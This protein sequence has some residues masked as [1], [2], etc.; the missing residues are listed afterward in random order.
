MDER[1]FLDHL[2]EGSGTDRDA[3]RV[4]DSGPRSI[5]VYFTGKSGP[6]SREFTVEP[7]GDTK[8]KLG[9]LFPE[10]EDVIANSM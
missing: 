1:T 5:R 9:Y 3:L 7:Y 8:D 6:Q 4:E 2:A 10:V